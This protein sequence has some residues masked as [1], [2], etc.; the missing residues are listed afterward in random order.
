[1]IEA[2]VPV[3]ICD[4]GGWTDTWF[5]GPGRVLNVAVAPGVEVSIRTSAGPGRGGLDVE[6]LGDRE[7]IVPGASRAARHPLL[8]A[9]IDASPPSDDVAVEVKIHS[10]APAGCGAG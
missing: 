3:R 9:A 2:S 6:N 8:E 7:S 1:M 4:N 5:G 10:A